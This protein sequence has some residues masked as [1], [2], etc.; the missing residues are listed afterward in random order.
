MNNDILVDTGVKKGVFK[1]SSITGWEIT[2]T[3]NEMKNIIK[4]IK[5]LGNRGIY[6]YK[7]YDSRRR[8]FQFS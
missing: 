7:S 4:V 6:Y 1:K 5:S 3:N 2:L 8:N